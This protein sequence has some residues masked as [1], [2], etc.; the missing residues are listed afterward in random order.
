[1]GA[2]E[3]GDDPVKAHRS[4]I[5]DAGAL[6]AIFEQ[7]L[8]NERACVKANGRLGDKITPAQSDE[9]GSAWPRTNEMNGHGSLVAAIAQLAPPSLIRETRRMEDGPAPASAAVSAMDGSPNSSV[10]FSERV[11]LRKEACRKTSASR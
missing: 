9:I 1:M 11:T 8:R 5:D 10:T 3:F 2:R 4:R 6:G 7:G